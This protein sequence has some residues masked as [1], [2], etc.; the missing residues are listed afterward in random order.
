MGKY[1]KK[2]IGRT[3]FI[4]FTGCWK[5]EIDKATKIASQRHW[6]AKFNDRYANLVGK[7]RIYQ[8]PEQLQT[9]IDKYFESCEGIRFNKYG[10]PVTDTDGQVVTVVVRP[11]TISGLANA[12]GVS[13]YVLRHYRVNAAMGNIPPAFAAVIDEAKQKVQQYAEEALYDMNSQRGAQ[14]VMQA[15]FYWNTRKEESD[16]ASAG[17]RN[18]LAKQEFDLK[19]SMLGE[20]IEDSEITINIVR[21]KKN[22]QED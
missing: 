2:A 12:I 8:T 3:L 17:I 5:R 1:F 21:P 15:G 20:G 13:T 16:I 22:R 19:K 14:F 11:Y 10:H 6:E 4:D 7:K 9:V 18:N